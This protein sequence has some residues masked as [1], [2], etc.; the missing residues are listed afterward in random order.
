MLFNSTIRCIIFYLLMTNFFVNSND[1][2][3]MF[4]NVKDQVAEKVDY[5][6]TKVKEKVQKHVFNVVF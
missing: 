5:A 1:I 4:N 2:F 6:S 3:D